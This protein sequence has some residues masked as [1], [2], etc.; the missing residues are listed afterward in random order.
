MIHIAS[1]DTPK[2]RKAKVIKFKAADFMN[3]GAIKKF[4]T[5]IQQMFHIFF[6]A[7]KGEYLEDWE[8]AAAALRALHKI[9]DALEDM[10]RLIP[11]LI[12]VAVCYVS[13][14]WEPMIA[15]E[16][17]HWTPPSALKIPA[18]F[19]L[20]CV[21]KNVPFVGQP[22]C[23]Y[24][25]LSLYNFQ[26]VFPWVLLDYP[27]G[28]RQGQ[29]LQD[30]YKFLSENSTLIVHNW[31][32]KI[33]ASAPFWLNIEILKLPG[34]SFYVILITWRKFPLNMG[35][36][37]QIDLPPGCGRDITYFKNA[38]TG[39]E[40]GG[41]VY[42][43]LNDYGTIAAAGYKQGQDG[44]LGSGYGGLYPLNK[45]LVENTLSK[46]EADVYVGH[47]F[48]MAIDNGLVMQIVKQASQE[49]AKKMKTEADQAGTLALE[50]V[51]TARGGNPAHYNFCYN[52]YGI[53][54]QIVV[55][56]I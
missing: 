15:Q 45:T 55:G 41:V 38:D 3:A 36:E 5:E 26:W 39:V 10:Q 49:I 50:N 9:K 40:I 1:H 12:R 32:L 24:M 25:F 37:P 6:V 19:P 13:H 23:I 4:I 47:L 44:S 8:T 52:S 14:W 11:N 16:L 31:L 53:I 21:S 51:S 48:K 17:L 18:L 22:E 28:V 29:D 2:P 30:N 54:V 42:N 27:N 33:S 56:A 7:G 35:V 20:V 43:A 34:T 46:E